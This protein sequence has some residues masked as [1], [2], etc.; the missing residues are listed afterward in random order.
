VQI[1]RAVAETV[2]YPGADGARVVEH[3]QMVP[4]LRLRDSQLPGQ[5]E[6]PERRILWSTRQLPDYLHQAATASAA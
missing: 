4:D 5:V 1:H 2:V 3:P 6:P